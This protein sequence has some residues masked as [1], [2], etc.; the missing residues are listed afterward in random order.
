MKT[1]SRTSN[2]EMGYDFMLEEYRSL[3]SKA[4]LESIV[5]RLIALSWVAISILI[6]GYQTQQLLSILIPAF[7]TGIM[8]R[9]VGKAREQTIT[10]L[11][12]VIIDLSINEENND[13][14]KAYINSRYVDRKHRQMMLFANYEPFLWAV[15][16]IGIIAIRYFL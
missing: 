10:R 8:W 1:T 11:E 3:S 7:F 12:K 14:K 15:I 6:N 5:F 2:N 16:T 4:N 13:V 9:F